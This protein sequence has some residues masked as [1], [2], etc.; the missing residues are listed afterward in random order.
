MATDPAKAIRDYP[1]SIQNALARGTVGTGVRGIA[2]GTLSKLQIPLPPISV[3]QEIGAELDGYQK[4]IEDARK[5]VGE[6]LAKIQ[7]RIKE[8]WGE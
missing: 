1:K 6:L 3:Q 2:R 8:V 4:E 7:D 5:R